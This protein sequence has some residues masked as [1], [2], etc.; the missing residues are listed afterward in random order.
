M[1]FTSKDFRRD[2]ECMKIECAIFDFD[3]TLFD[4]MFI[5]DNVGEIYLRSLG[6][7]PKASMNK[8]VRTLS[9]YQSA[10]YFKEK[11]EIA[12][13]VEEIMAGINQTIEH[14]YIYEVQPK[15]SVISFLSELKQQ[16][17]SICIAT[18]S[19]RYQIEAALKRCGIEDIFEAVFTCT[20][21][22]HGKD[23]PVIFRKAM[24]YF[25]ADRSNTVVFEDALH[26]IQT[27]KK[28][29][30]IVASVFDRSEKRQN[31]IRD[32]SDCYIPDFEHL[33]EFWEFVLGG[34]R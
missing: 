32:I 26:A 8:D 25:D 5:W 30:F 16:G 7:E 19:D 4:S 6:K 24:E 14:F 11:Y 20:E 9:L 29:G 28:D 34:K 21:V 12:L 13:S 17:I 33:E 15:A 18:A 22:G 27:A 3:G 2:G 23:E 31:E 1:S 10:C